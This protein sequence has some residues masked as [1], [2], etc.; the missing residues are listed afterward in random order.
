MPAVKNE[1]LDNSRLPVL[2]VTRQK[3]TVQDLL[4]SHNRV[5]EFPV[6]TETHLF[7]GSTITY[8]GIFHTSSALFFNLHSEIE[9]PNKHLHYVINFN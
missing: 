4:T 2:A 7:N 3:S 8:R 5:E 9:R 6:S 1:K